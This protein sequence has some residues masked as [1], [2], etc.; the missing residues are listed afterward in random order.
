MAEPSNLRIPYP[1]PKNYH[2]GNGSLLE[3]AHYDS[4]GILQKKKVFTYSFKPIPG[5]SPLY[6]PKFWEPISPNSGLQYYE[7]K[8]EFWSLDT[9]SDT[10]YFD[11]GQKTVAKQTIY[12]YNMDNRLV[13]GTTER[14]GEVNLITA[15]KYALHFTDAAAQKM[16][17]KKMIGIPLE[18][19]TLKNGKIVAGDKSE[20]YIDP[21]GVILKKKSYSLKIT[22][23]LTIGNY[24][25]SYEEDYAISRYDN[26]HN[27][28]EIERRDGSRDVYLWSYNGQ[29]LMAE[30][31]NSDYSMVNSV[32]NS[33]G[34]TSVDA[35]SALSVPDLSK[36][37]LLRTQ[38]ALNNAYVTTFQYKPLV[39]VTQITDPAG[40]T[41][42]YEY[43]WLGRMIRVTD[44]DR[45]TIQENGYHYKT[46]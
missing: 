27:P 10:S 24:S 17:E 41:T 13:A 20:Y 46:Q 45:Y 22:P 7:I 38:S 4:E 31:K 5:A 30:V 33:I 26:F 19:L 23:S 40:V 8:P 14:M 16:K 11:H 36:L 43:D 32:L 6:I 37:D 1:I 9:V 18:A 35:L 2:I 3:E 34:L 44:A 12:K 15:T 42:Y 28:V 21:S 39:G 29:Y 25:R